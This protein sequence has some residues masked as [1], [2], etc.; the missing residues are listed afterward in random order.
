M[1]RINRLDKSHK[2]EDKCVF[3]MEQIHRHVS[4]FWSECCDSKV[5]V[6]IKQTILNFTILKLNDFMTSFYKSVLLKPQHLVSVKT[7]RVF[8]LGVFPKLKKDQKL[9]GESLWRHEVCIVEVTVSNSKAYTNIDSCLI[10]K[11]GVS[12]PWPSTTRNTDRKNTDRKN[13]EAPVSH[14]DVPGL[15]EIGHS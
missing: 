2:S 7:R 12:M 6:I 1:N 14:S 4:V 11:R 9:E 3:F 13:T 10:E 8:P 5:R 15:F